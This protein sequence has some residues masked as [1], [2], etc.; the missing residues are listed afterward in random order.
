MT[1]KS[2]LLNLLAQNPNSLI[3]GSLGTI[4]YDLG[5]I[6][7]ERKVLIKGAMGS[8]LGFGLGYALGAPKEDVIVVIGEGSLLMHLGSLSTILAHDLPNLRIIVLNNGQ[9]KSCGGQTNN[10]KYIR[11]YLP[12]EVED[13]K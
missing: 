6:E 8:P 4:S 3:V 13:V 1:Q 7:H 10:F 2:Y 5:E 12:V 9:Y 11:E